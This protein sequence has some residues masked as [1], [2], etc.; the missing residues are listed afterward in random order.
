MSLTRLLIGLSVLSTLAVV[1][2]GY[3]GITLIES[4]DVTLGALAVIVS[5]ATACLPVM[6]ALFAQDAHTYGTVS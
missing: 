1:T 2:L 4:G 6:L 3:A 5:M